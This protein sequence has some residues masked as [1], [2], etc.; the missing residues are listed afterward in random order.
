V[1]TTRDDPAP[2]QALPVGCTFTESDWRV[3]ADYWHPVAFSRDVT[4]APVRAR[5]L[6][7]DLVIYRTSKGVVVARNLCLH[8]G[9]ELTQGRMEGDEL[10]CAYHGFRYGP[11]GQCTRIPS[12]PASRRISPK[13]R[14]L[15]YP[16]QERYGLVWTCLSGR[17]RRGL[18]DW[19]E[20]EDDG[21]RWLGLEPLDWATS[22]ARQVDNF[23]DVSHFPFV[24][25]NTFGNAAEPEIPEIP[26]RLTD[27]GLAYEFD[28]TANNPDASPMDGGQ[29]LV[30]ETSYHVTLPFAV[31]LWERFPDRVDQEAYH[32]VFNVAAPVSAKRTRAFFFVCRNFDFDV[33][34]EEILEWEGRI[35]GEDQVIVEGQRPEELPL[36]LTE[37]YHVQADRMTIAYRRQLAELGL[38]A[39]YSA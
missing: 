19:P 18:P 38:G 13:V 39:D 37:E 17:P 25:A 4:T 27:Y 32:V 28:F 11:E 2:A 12:Q 35:M 24:H 31:R 29:T 33:P 7:L 10:V 15:T 23:L 1:T 9:S 30:W 14:L 5:L 26:V 21:Y 3:L 36:D 6:D 20:A 16:V 22:A 8:R 34:A